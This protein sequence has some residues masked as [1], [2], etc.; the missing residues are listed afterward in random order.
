[1][2]KEKRKAEN[3]GKLKI[4]DNWNAITIIA[5][6]QNNPLKAIAEFVEN[7]IDADAKNITI[8][9]G[10]QKGSAYLKI[11]DDG[12][13]IDDFRYVA[14]HIGDS[15]K[16]ELKKKGATG[17]Q[18]E[19][20]IG[21]L[22]FWTV[23]EELAIT[24]KGKSG[25]TRKM[26]LVKQ[27][28]G[29]SIKDVNTL[30]GHTGTELFI[31]PILP[32]I[33]QLAGEKIQNYLASE[34]RDRIIRH[35]INI[36]IVDKSSKKD[37]TVEPRK[38]SGRLIRSLPQPRNPLGEIYTEL[39]IAEP[40]SGNTTGL[41]RH[42]TRVLESMTKLEFFNRNPWSSPY[43]E[44]LIDCTFLQ[45]TPGTRDGIIL[46]SEYESFCQSM[47]QL[48]E[49]LSAVIEE[50]KKAEEEK[51]SITIL[52]RISKALK[53]AFIH[54]PPE[55]YGWLDII[56]GQKA[57]V[58]KPGPVEAGRDYPVG[59]DVAT[60]KNNSGEAG[61]GKSFALENVGE[62][63]KQKDFFSYP[64]P[65]FSAVISPSSLIIGTGKKKMLR[66]VARDR[67]RR[68]LD[69]GF[70]SEWKIIEGEGTLAASEGVFNEFEAPEEPGITR[71]GVTVS[72]DETTCSAECIVTVTS[73]LFESRKEGDASSS[74]KK[75][76]P[77]Y[78][79]RKAPGEL[80]RS[81]YDQGKGIVVINSGHADF[82]YASRVK[83]R[84]LK[85]IGKL[86]SKE[87]VLANFPESGKEQLLERIIEL[88]LYMEENL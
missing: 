74:G 58:L 72:Q 10:R 80:W 7:S 45:L 84:Q 3:T 53:E 37:L 34:L 21:L 68:E 24:S 14:T 22:S 23:G 40:S 16:R 27:N 29:Y 47:L 36:R 78:T 32:G 15:I 50:Q 52:N 28:P 79:Y 87:L 20:G 9:R 13:G 17:I 19:F 42:G 39:Y 88:Q 55:E 71:I 5:L 82:I 43:L 35:R 85:Y 83:S 81:C 44:G 62:P 70:S 60:D 86:F 61:I 63:A 77:G 41:Y 38:F 4:G 18:G 48:E 30:F 59:D 1:M 66:L 46:D 51:T 57:K 2:K 33:K 67:N 56:H 8:L 75:G 12:S 76:I 69:S 6:S 25:T 26:T 54:L 31:S 11:I 64:G 65:L 73:E 49:P